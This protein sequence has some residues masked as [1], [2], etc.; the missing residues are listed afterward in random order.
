MRIGNHLRVNAADVY[1]PAQDEYVDG[2]EILR[3]GGN[4]KVPIHELSELIEELKSH[5][6]P[7]HMRKL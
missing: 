6:P 1:V 7:N 5:V 2:V 4:V 3:M